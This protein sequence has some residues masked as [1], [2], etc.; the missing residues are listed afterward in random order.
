VSGFVRA[1]DRLA[2]GC[3]VF[4]AACLVLAML[5]VVWMVIWR[6]TG[7]STYWEIELA[8]YL[9]VATVLIGSPYTLMTQGH[10]GVDLLGH[11]MNPGAR[12]TL[13]RLLAVL[14]FMVCLYLAWRGLELTAEA[15]QK[16]ETSGSA[17]N[18]P[19]WPFYALMPVGLGLTA[20]QYLAEMLR[21]RPAPAAAEIP[22]S[23]QGA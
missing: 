17:W 12:R 1:V 2:V 8:T 10:I 4:A 9:I 15:L 19:R 14:G 3:A 11:Y 13:T 6:A 18:P 23:G 5:I 22:V 7:H 16:N 20:L 21:T